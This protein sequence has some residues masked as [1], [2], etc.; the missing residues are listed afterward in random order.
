MAKVVLIAV[1]SECRHALRRLPT[2]NVALASTVATKFEGCPPERTASPVIPETRS[3][4]TPGANDL[5]WP[6]MT[7]SLLE[8]YMRSCAC[9]STAGTTEIFQ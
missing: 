8:G 7:V 5:R 4:M 6:V 9:S 2:A 3:Y 1:A